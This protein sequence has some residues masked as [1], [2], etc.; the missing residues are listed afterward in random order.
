MA[1]IC[2]KAFQHL[3]NIPLKALWMVQIKS[4]DLSATPPE[5]MTSL[6]G[7]MP[8]VTCFCRT[9]KS[10]TAFDKS[11]TL[12]PRNPEKKRK[13]QIG[14]HS[15]CSLTEMVFCYQNCFDLLWSHVRRN[16]SSDRE[17]LLK[18]EAE[19]REFAKFLRSL[20]QFI[21]T[22]KQN[23]ALTCSWRFL[24]S[25]KLEQLKFKLKRI[26]GI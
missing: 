18:F 21:W 6:C 1:K 4:F 25:N 7:G 10:V 22:V 24:I 17:K 16:C 19:G 20:E 11:N 26:I 8:T 15:F 12:L 5:T 13:I 14:I 3:V 9:S 23:A 2:Q